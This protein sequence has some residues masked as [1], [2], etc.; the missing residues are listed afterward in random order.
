M[1]TTET[2]PVCITLGEARRR[3][4]RWRRTRA[5]RHTPVPDALWAAAVALAQEH[6]RARTARTLGLDYT[7]L[8]RR[9]DATGDARSAPISPTFVELP[10][11]VSSG[12][13]E[14]VIELEGAG[15]GTVRIRVKDLALPDVVALTRVVLER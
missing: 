5:H 1:V 3:V 7:A 11:L 2:I 4:E 8:K 15:G 6:G 12:L 10:P 13:G 14:C 9:L